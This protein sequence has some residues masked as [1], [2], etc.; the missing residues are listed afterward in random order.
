MVLVHGLRVRM[1]ASGG[2]MSLCRLGQ[3]PV[4]A[5][6]WNLQSCQQLREA[7]IS[8]LGCTRQ[9]TLIPGL[10]GQHEAL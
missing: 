2:S 1:C 10:P 6:R 3:T 8:R 4:L 5:C 9:G 7:V